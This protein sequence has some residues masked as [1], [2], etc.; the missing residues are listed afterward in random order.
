MIRAFN[1]MVHQH[2]HAQA[3]AMHSSSGSPFS[4]TNSGD[5]S[6]SGG[7]QGVKRQEQTSLAHSSLGRKSADT[8]NSS[9]QALPSLRGKSGDTPK[10]TK[11]AKQAE[12]QQKKA[13]ESFHKGVIRSNR[14]H[15]AKSVTTQGL[16]IGDNHT[17]KKG[18]VGQRL[19]Q[20]EIV[21]RFVVNTYLQVCP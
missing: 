18:G 14:I 7:D 3:T 9:K 11:Q 20:P 15:P 4:A 2:I 13:R 16:L 10:P 1:V 17:I 8:P 21:H 19:K 12:A 6:L 5:L